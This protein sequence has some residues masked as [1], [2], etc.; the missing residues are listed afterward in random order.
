MRRH[1]LLS[2]LL[3]LG[4]SAPARCA[5]KAPAGPSKKNAGPHAVQV[6][7]FDW[8]DAGRN[9]LVP[10]KIYLPEGKGPFPVV[11]FSHGLG[12]SREDY[13]YIG[14]HWASHGYASIHPQHLRDALELADAVARP[15]DVRY[16]LDRLETAN[17]EPGPLQGKLD[18]RRAGMAGHSFGAWT[19]LAVAGQTV[20]GEGTRLADSRVRAG[21]A[22]SPSLP[23]G[24]MDPGEVYGA[25]RMPILHMTGT[26]DDSPMGSFPK[27]ADRRIPFDHIRGAEQYLVIFDGGDHHIFVGYR[28]ERGSKEALFLDLIRQ[29]STAF[30]DAYLKEDAAAK[31]WLAEGGFAAALGTAGR[32]ETKRANSR[33]A[34]SHRPARGASARRGR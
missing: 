25:I 5:S 2:L 19:T 34:V 17:R 32:W 23:A 28:A 9:R 16:V 12:G 4:L 30:W 29:S 20:P 27:A 21:I 22:M 14:R 3:I 26:L 11:V 24:K 31:R 10:V 6:H 7:R 13:E 15:L 18:L 1:A 33:D 8:T